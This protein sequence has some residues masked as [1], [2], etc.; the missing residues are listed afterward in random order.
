MSKTSVLFFIKNLGGGGAERVLV[1]LLHRLNPEKFDITVRTI[2]DE[3][4][5]R[6]QLPAHVTYKSTLPKEF[7]GFVHLAKL[8]S[9]KTLYNFFIK[10]KYDITVAFLE[11]ITTRIAS[12]CNNKET[13][14]ISWL[15]LEQKY[16]SVYL[17]PYRSLKEMEISYNSFDYICSASHFAL[18]S[19]KSIIHLKPANGVFHNIIDTEAIIRKGAEEITEITF[20]RDIIRLG[21]VGR[22]THQKG[23]LRLIRVLGRLKQDGYNFQFYL[24]G[25]GDEEQ[26]IRSEIRKNNL[27][28]V[29]HLLGFRENPYKFIRNFD[30]FIGSS[31]YEGFSLVICEA[32]ILGV[33]AIATFV[34]GLDEITNT[35]NQYSY[36]VENSENGLY[37][38]LKK[39][40]ND[41]S[42]IDNL[43]HH[44][45]QSARFF[46]TAAAADKVSELF[47]S[48]ITR[49]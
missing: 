42:I 19:L 38:G 28:S 7:P 21:S 23:Y 37:N 16:K 30:L 47:L 8:F 20:P 26:E 9:R 32:A 11:G 15:H 34:S 49:K 29:I 22:L 14:L 40:L 25:K 45:L 46:N 10:E 2:F 12:G 4:I 33:P 36:T 44:C 3:G 6:N 41:R 17:K 31:Y 43:K 18:D 35:T 5:Y 1:D 48:L 39:L 13:K 24:L 27:E